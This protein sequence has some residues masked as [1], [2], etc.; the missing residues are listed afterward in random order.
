MDVKIHISMVGDLEMNSNR[1]AP[2]PVV[3][4]G[5]GISGLAAAHRLTQL[6]RARPLRLLEASPRVGGVLETTSEHGFL[7]EAAAD[8]FY[9]PTI[10]VRK[11]CHELGLG[12]EI[13]AAE[14]T[15]KPV[16]LVH[17]GELVASPIEFLSGTPPSVR[18]I[19]TTPLLSW[20]GKCRVFGERRIAPSRSDDESCASFFVRRFG[21]EFYTALV[22]PVL[23][24]IY[25]ADPAI[26]SMQALLPHIRDMEQRWGSLTA[27]YR[28]RG[29]AAYTRS[30]HRSTNGSWTLRRGMASLTS[31]LAATLP[32]GAVEVNAP[33]H[34]LHIDGDR[35][36]H[37]D[38]GRGQTLQ[39]AAVVLATPAHRAAHLLE[40][41]SS[42]AARLLQHVSYSSVA[43]IALGYHRAQIRGPLTSP[44]FFVPEHEPFE[45]RSA[46]LPSVKY[47]GRAPADAVLIRASL[48]G[49]RHASI[50]GQS[51]AELIQLADQELS[52]LLKIQG[53]PGFSRV[54]RQMFAMPQYRLGHPELIDAVRRRLADSPGLALAGNAYSGIGVPYC[55]ASGQQAAE[56]VHRYLQATAV[57]PTASAAGT[58]MATAYTEPTHA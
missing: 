40:P 1:S 23:S 25:S 31:A 5:G 11:L 37:I 9:H 52:R 44:G 35:T 8:G 30:R 24:G 19:L 41:L 10:Q 2:S 12:D 21:V 54:Q 57:V 13:L 14:P 17:R 15:P 39:A 46:S 34:R 56:Q 28:Q 48:G 47:A 32:R 20:R 33:V 55:I 29:P 51:D 53:G 7:W 18:A 49:D 22:G 38:Y 45:L 16:Q 4:I 36:W 58:Y 6:D 3:V 26:L 42:Y 43:V 27:A 50:V